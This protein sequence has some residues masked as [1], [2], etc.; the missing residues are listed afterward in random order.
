LIFVSLY[1]KAIIIID[2]ANAVFRAFAEY[3]S[4]T[5]DRCFGCLIGNYIEI[6]KHNG[7]NDFDTPHF[8]NRKRQRGGIEDLCTSPIKQELID[9]AI[10]EIARLNHHP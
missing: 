9:N 7:G 2:Y 3:V 4:D 1:F 10:L 8:G 6:L 5:L